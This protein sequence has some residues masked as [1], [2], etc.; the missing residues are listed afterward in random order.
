MTAAERSE[1]DNV[2]KR[3]AYNCWSMDL[4]NYR[5]IQAARTCKQDALQELRLESEELYQQAIQVIVIPLHC[6]Y[7]S[8]QNII[9]TGSSGNYNYRNYV[10][11]LKNYMN[12]QFSPRNQ[13]V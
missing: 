6:I 11:N 13:A 1:E 2:S 7:V 3:F 5:A 12:R 4:N 8:N 10:W 9:S